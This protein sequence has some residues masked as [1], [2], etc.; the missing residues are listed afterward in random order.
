M[1]DKLR[2]AGRQVAALAAGLDPH[3]LTPAQAAS[4]LEVFAG[5]EKR[6]AAARLLLAARAAESA[7]WRRT[8]H[9]SAI[10]WL[11]HE[12]GVT[13]SEARRMLG[14]SAQLDDLPD[15]TDAL[16]QG[17]LSGD[18]ADEIVATAKD[19]P[20]SER[21]LLD[22]VARGASLDHLKRVGRR[23]RAAASGDET[24]RRERLH[25]NRSVRFFDDD[26]GA[27]HLDARGL[28][29]VLAEMKAHLTPFIDQQFHAARREGR[30][31]PL[32]AYAFDAL[33]AMLRTASGVD[34]DPSD[35][36]ADAPDTDTDTEA[37]PAKRRPPAEVIVLAS[38]DALRRGH[39]QPGETCEIPGVG[40][41]SVAAARDHLGD[42]LL[43]LVITDGTDINTVVRFGRGLTPEQRI[44][45]LVRD[46]ECVVPGCHAT[47]RLEAHHLIPF[48][49]TGHTTLRELA[50][51]CHAEHDLATHHGYELRGRPGAWE[52]LTPEQI[53]A[54]RDP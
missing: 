29:E 24:T 23:R 15:T 51:I 5:I 18:Q 17:E 21:S 39:T 9:R 11:A 40:P 4:A 31:E 41:V 12:A 45:L 2:D 53:T 52:W 25:R 6:A 10:D 54:A 49:K 47:E 42:A 1:F 28:P 48:A 22:E 7:L 8:G 19:D 20:T 34:P 33:L 37:S 30:R 13:L 50:R 36:D 27:T 16:R 32:A 38:L 26:E 14:A 35:A 43:S 44:A 3:A 46:R